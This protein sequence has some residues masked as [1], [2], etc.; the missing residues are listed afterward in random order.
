LARPSRRA[1]K[2]FPFCVIANRL[3]RHRRIRLWRKPVACPPMAGSNLM[4]RAL[5]R[6]YFF[7][8]LLNIPEFSMTLK[9]LNGDVIILSIFFPFLPCHGQAPDARAILRGE[10]AAL[11]RHASVEYDAT[12]HYKSLDYIDTMVLQETCKLI[13]E[14][15][16]SI[17]GAKLFM[18]N[19]NATSQRDTFNFLYD[20]QNEYAIFPTR[21]E[22]FPF[23]IHH[24]E[25]GDI[26]HDLHYNLSQNIIWRKFLDPQPLNTL[27]DASITYLGKDTI[28]DIPCDK[29]YI[30]PPV[31]GT[32]TETWSFKIWKYISEKD[33]VSVYTKHETTHHGK[34]QYDDFLLNRYQFD[35]VPDITLT[36]ELDGNY[37]FIA[38]SPDSNID[39]MLDSGVTFPAI[40]G[41]LAER[42]MKDTTLDL[43]GNVTVLD[44]WNK[45]C[46]W[47]I[48]SFPAMEKLFAKYNNVA[49]QMYGIDVFD[50]SR[51]ALKAFPKV[52]NKY[53]LSYKTLVLNA[54]IAKKISVKTN[55]EYYIID[56]NGK[57]A[58]SQCGVSDDLFTKMDTKIGELLKK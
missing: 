33:S 5:V 43:N 17:W 46:P 39:H 19:V 38:F 29:I 37:K 6:M 45:G 31:E 15:D 47:C 7:N 57:V 34:V 1:R 52:L 58:F 2:E 3:F 25:I 30:V 11:A 16:D 48:K 32:G 44:C 27:A 13:R 18:T 42:K 28:S 40:H 4:I 24:G 56:K 41:K 10:S 55:P 20:L 54:E 23:D 51:E 49:F 35:R 21:K 26:D 36:H 12:V 9:R 14:P 8:N 53:H 50:T 22:V